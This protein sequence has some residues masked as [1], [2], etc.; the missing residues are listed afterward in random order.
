MRRLLVVPLIV[1]VLAGCKV[2]TKLS[3][4][5]RDDGSGTVVLEVVLDADAVS[6]AEAGGALLEDRVRLGD[7]EAAGWASTDWERRNDGIARL[8]VS[9]DFATASELG[10]VIEE[11]DGPDGPLQDVA[12]SFDD[13]IVFDRYRFGG[14][15]DLSQL[16][17]GVLDDPEI[18]A[19][20]TAQQVDLTA[21]DLRLVDQ[22]QRSFALEVVVSLPGEGSRTFAAAPGETV[23]LSASSRQFDPSRSLLLLAASGFAALALLIFVRGLLV[24]RR[25]R[26]R[27]AQGRG[28][29]SSRA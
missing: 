3:I 23:T 21:L 24:D 12:L 27:R 20:L 8:R 19:A 22:L 13:G 2:D 16:R 4:D 6:E 11:L 17:T 29:R 5:V 10:G 15:A 9:K 14:V 28:S 25:R 18:V 26:R 1:L 7:L